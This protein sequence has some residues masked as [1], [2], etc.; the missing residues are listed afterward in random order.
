VVD[1]IRRGAGDAE[2]GGAL[3]KEIGF[4]D[5]GAEAIAI[6]GTDAEIVILA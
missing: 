4:A 5:R 2:M 6:D 3:S 1:V